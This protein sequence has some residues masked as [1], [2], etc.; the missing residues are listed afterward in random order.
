MEYH[1]VSAISSETN[2]IIDLSTGILFLLTWQA[3]QALLSQ[4]GRLPTI[5]KIL[6]AYSLVT[7]ALATVGFGANAEYTQMIYVDLRD[8]PGGPPVLIKLALDYWQDR[9]AIAA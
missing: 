7:F 1:T 5:K 8:T 9:L 4:K 2:V 3:I 6:I